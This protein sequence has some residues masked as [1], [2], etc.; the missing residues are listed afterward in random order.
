MQDILQGHLQ[1]KS[2]LQRTSL[3]GSVCPLL[4]LLLA[5]LLPALGLGEI[6]A[7]HAQPTPRHVLGERQPAL[8]AVVT[9]AADLDGDGDRDVLSGGLNQVAWHENKGS[10]AFSDRMVITNDGDEI[11]RIQAR[12]LDGDGDLDVVSRSR[13]HVSWHE[14][15]G[16]GEFSGRREIVHREFDNETETV[17]GRLAS[18]VTD[19]NG[20]G[21][22]DLVT[23]LEGRKAVYWRE[24]AGEGV[25]ADRKQL[26]SE[27]RAVRFLRS[28]DLDGD[29]DADLLT[30]SK[31]NG[32][33]ALHENTSGEDSLSFSE[34]VIDSGKDFPVLRVTDLDGDTDP[35]IVRFTDVGTNV[36][37]WYQNDGSGQFS[38][39]KTIASGFAEDVSE[40][41]RI[42]TGDFEGDGDRDV[43]VSH[44]GPE[45]K[46][47][48]FENQG[49]ATFSGR[50]ILKGPKGDTYDEEG[51]L[52]L[53]RLDGD[54][55]PDVLFA[56][57]SGREGLFWR[58]NR[59]GGGS[60]FG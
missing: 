8:T 58:S 28:A 48:W 29:S 19:L 31:F 21:L 57:K 52:R 9:A 7:V 35:D 23:K 51:A 45:E 5:A 60:G 24:N 11:D 37:S 56:G 2:L 3:Q 55:R 27:K 40:P 25:F 4:A 12:D 20:D 47:S 36:L 43:L 49:Q 32:T 18:T 13:R 1:R 17:V 41:S 22:P 39:E 42:R 38:A 15:R 10:G 6:G 54:K 44:G 53:A 26:F 46:L 59:F 50:Q 33:L 16:G 14:N 34:S 30:W